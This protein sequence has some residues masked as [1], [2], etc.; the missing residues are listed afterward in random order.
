VFAIVKV[1]SSIEGVLEQKTESVAIDTDRQRLSAAGKGA[2]N[3]RQTDRETA[4][5]A[6]VVCVG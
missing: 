6:A 2:P 3:N 1:S 4:S 5:T